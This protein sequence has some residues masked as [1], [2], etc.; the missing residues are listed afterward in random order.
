MGF[1]DEH[2]PSEERLREAV[3]DTDAAPEGFVVA[4]PMSVTIFEDGPRP[5]ASK[6]ASLSS[7]SRILVDALEA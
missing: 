7:I 4:C 2:K 6:R 5:V 1:E 3:E